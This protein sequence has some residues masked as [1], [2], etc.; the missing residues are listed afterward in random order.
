MRITRIAIA[1]PACLAIAL[2]ACGNNNKAKDDAP[3]PPPPADAAIDAAVVKPCTGPT[4]GTT[5]TTRQVGATIGDAALLVT[6]PA[7]DPRLFVVG[8]AGKIRIIENEVLRDAPFL[9]LSAVVVAGGELGL[10]G[11]AFHP[12]YATN[13]EF[14]VY[15]TRREANDAT[16]PF[17]DVVARCEVKADDPYTADPTSCVEILAIPDFASNHNGG[18]IEFGS[19]GFLYIG[20]GDGGNANDPNGNGQT[21]VDGAPL[22][23]SQALL[24]KLLRIDV[25]NPAGGKQYGIPDT[26]PFALGGGAP[27]IFAL[28]LRNPWRWSFDRA[29]GDMWIGDV[30]QGAIEELDVVKAGELAGKN[31]GW[32]MYE[33]STCFAGR[34][35]NNGPCDPTGITFA[36]D[37]R[38]HS[39]DGWLAIIG[40]Q[41]YR[42]ACY[43]DIAGTYFYT[44][45]SK[46]G[47]AS[48]TFNATDG[49]IA[50][51][52]LP[53][54]FP[55]KPA[56]IHAAADGELYLTTV[57]GGVFHIEAGP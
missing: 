7:N 13:H 27:E 10:L 6:A 29:T 32:D 46:G 21:L 57:G 55:S 54:T 40:G 48:A 12:Q 23:N 50:K 45:N 49:T 2:V 44:D 20:T 47:L 52:D 56:S 39:G 34:T 31:F 28:G 5:I 42:G 41:V 15:Y 1:R 43:P 35:P 9:D 38:T 22:A 18:M 37:E 4:S 17:R 24:A 8:R 36:Q 53:G 11:L 19:D 26:N 33:G 51:Q 25:D 14:F 30:G 3:P 16:N